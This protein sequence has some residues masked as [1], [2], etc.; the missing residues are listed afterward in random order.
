MDMDKHHDN[1][2]QKKKKKKEILTSDAFNFASGYFIDVRE[3]QK[4]EIAYHA[5]VTQVHLQSKKYQSPQN[6]QLKCLT[7]SSQT[8]LYLHLHKQIVKGGGH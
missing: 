1:I 5:F 3:K 2:L 4:Y 7:Q 6:A 8:S